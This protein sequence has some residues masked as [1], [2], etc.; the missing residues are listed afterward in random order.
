MSANIDLYIDSSGGGLQSG[1]SAQG[2]NL[3]IFTRNDVYT[4]RLRILD[5]TSTGTLTDA[6]LTGAS[7]KLG[8]GSID[9]L[10]KDGEFQLTRPGPVT[11]SAIS[12]NATTTQVFNAISGIAG[13]VT[14]ATYGSAENS[15]LIT[16]ASNG[17]ALSFGGVPYTLF[18]ASSVLIS[19]R[20]QQATNVKQQQIIQL[21][22]N[23]V[24][25][26]DT[27]VNSSTAT[28]FVLSKIQSGG[29]G[30]N[31]TY[32][33]YTGRDA[34]SG[35]FSL[36]F[37][38]NTTT[39]LAV[40]ANQ[41]NLYTALQSVPE[42]GVGNISVRSIEN[43]Q[44]YIITFTG[45]LGNTNITTPLTLDASGVYFIPFKNASVTFSTAE[46]NEVFLDDGTTSVTL[47][48]EIELTKDGE[49]KTLAQIPVT[50][51]K[52]LITSG[53]VVPAPLDS[54][55]TKTQSDALFIQNSASNIN[56]SN[57][58]LADS[59]SVT[60]VDWGNRKLYKGSSD[61]F[62]WNGG[63]GFY[64]TT[65]IS[66]PSGTNVVSN[67]I[68]LGL[69]GSSSTYGVLPQSQRTLTTT[70]SINFG[71]IGGNDIH[72][73]DVVVTGSKIND[74]V[75][76]GNPSAI[77]NGLIMQGNVYTQNTVCMQCINGFSGT[78]SVGTETY[79]IT[80]IGY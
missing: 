39:A 19:T 53:S 17:T 1:G 77:S 30:T 31:E 75:L 57:R 61:Y 54:F 64:G 76:I 3:P 11:S 69:I 21:R 26:A 9:L 49:P 12:Y 62:S 13:Q 37:G 2:A 58:F 4:F 8:I 5:I 42:I 33:L 50:I 18:P 71:T 56:S 52:D 70:A 67:V 36:G 25:Y 66:K 44:G 16:A 38:N 74:I 32:K 55:Y 22:R 27:F 48:M 43:S 10:P 63:I 41:A 40:N 72:S 29:T 28:E 73:S 46:L 35:S 45:A 59:S 47:T 7:L 51:R 14:V 23:P 68:S 80:V 34:I 78:R 24:V 6:D 79:R 20:R 60:S 15:W 65:A